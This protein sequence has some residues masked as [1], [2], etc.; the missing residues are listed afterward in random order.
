M[1]WEYVAFIELTPD[2]SKSAFEFLIALAQSNST[3]YQE[4]KSIIA[5]HGLSLEAKSLTK[6]SI[7]PFWR[8]TTFRRPLV[9][10]I[11]LFRVQASPP[12]EYIPLGILLHGIWAQSINIS[13]DQS[14]RD[15]SF[16][17]IQ[18][19]EVVIPGEM[20]EGAANLMAETTLGVSIQHL[21]VYD[22]EE[23]DACYSKAA[24]TMDLNSHF[25]RRLIVGR[26]VDQVVLDIVRVDQW[27]W[28]WL[29]KYLHG[30]QIQIAV[31][32]GDESGCRV[33]F[34]PIHTRLTE[35][36]PVN[37]PTYDCQIRFDKV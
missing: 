18:R 23:A 25:P 34:G 2:N 36:P 10:K 24:Y 14:Q 16:A 21:R 15:G 28:T 4:L 32:D 33:T 1:I 11:K 3:V 12:V 30:L 6:T 8:S 5:K 31:S 37:T 7:K 27:Q 9:P 19:L 35:D 26:V 29:V 22:P 20:W 13:V 17:P